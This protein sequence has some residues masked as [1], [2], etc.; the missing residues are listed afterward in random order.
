M[1]YFLCCFFHSTLSCK[2]VI[3]LHVAE[4]GSFQCLVLHVLLHVATE[5]LGVAGVT[6]ELNF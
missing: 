4:V 6:E 2:F 1:Y 5:Y 3:L